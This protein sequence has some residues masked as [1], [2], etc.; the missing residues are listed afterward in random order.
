M[1]KQRTAII[2]IAL[3]SCLLIAAGVLAN[4]NPNIDWWVLGGGGGQ[5]SGNQ[6]VLD[7]TLGQ[8]VTGTSSGGSNSLDAGFWH[9]AGEVTGY[10]YLPLVSR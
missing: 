3:I 10:V 6:I 1:N 5:A 2:T 8:P 9:G 4:G 7:A